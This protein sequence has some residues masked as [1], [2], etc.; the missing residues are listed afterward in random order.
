MVA[1]ESHFRFHTHNVYKQVLHFIIQHYPFL[2]LK[3]HRTMLKNTNQTFHL[4]VYTILCCKAKMKNI[5]QPAQNKRFEKCM[6]CNKESL[7]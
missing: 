1:E 6:R 2:H 4:G 7:F 5:I 3:I